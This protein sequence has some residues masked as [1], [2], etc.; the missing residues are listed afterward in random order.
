MWDEPWSWTR[1]KFASLRTLT[2]IY[3]CAVTAV[4]GLA[5]LFAV[6]SYGLGRG[7]FFPFVLI[8]MAVVAVAAPTERPMLKIA[9]RKLH[10]DRSDQSET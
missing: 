2:K 8:A 3:V 1:G 9:A 10:S 4:L 5:A 6:D 7:A